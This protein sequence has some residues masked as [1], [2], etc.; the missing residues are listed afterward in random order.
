[1]HKLFSRIPKG[2]EPIADIFKEHIDGEGMK[3]V[4]EAAGAAESK[5]DK[6]KEAGESNV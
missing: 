5:K 1:M 6:D 2:L 4:K 3:L